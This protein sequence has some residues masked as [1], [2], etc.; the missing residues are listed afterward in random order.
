MNFY[1]PRA[2]DKVVTAYKYSPL[3]IEGHAS[4]MIRKARNLVKKGRNLMLFQCEELANYYLGFNGW[5]S[6]ILYHQLECI[7]STEQTFATAVELSF[8]KDF[9]GFKA[10]G[11]GLSVAKFKNM[12]EKTSQIAIAQKTSKS[13]AILNAFS[14]VILVL[15]HAEEKKTKVTLRIDSSK[16]DPFYYNSLWD[17]KPVAEVQQLEHEPESDKAVVL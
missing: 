3:I 1:S 2:A 4:L 16:R 5:T 12:T 17:N 10:E 14:K 13:A 15:V 6:E 8:L 11:V 9:E 7:K